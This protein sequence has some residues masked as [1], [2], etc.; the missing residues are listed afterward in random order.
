MIRENALRQ[1]IPGA[2]NVVM[3]W[4]IWLLDRMDELPP[5]EAP[6]YILHSNWEP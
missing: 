1:N 5:I 6:A 3:D 2:E 4:A